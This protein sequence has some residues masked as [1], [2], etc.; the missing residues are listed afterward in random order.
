MNR[1]LKL[2]LDFLFGLIIPIIILSRFSDELGN[3]TAYVVS[4]LIPV[5]WV[6]I[7]LL[8]IT[9]RFNFITSFLGLNAVLRGILAFWF[10]DGVA[11][12][13]KDSASSLLWVV[14]FGGSL[15]YG[16]PLFGAFVEQGLGPQDTQQE[17][18]IKEFFREKSVHRAI[19]Y[20]TLGMVVVSAVATVAN[21]FLNLRIVTA[22]FGTSGFNLQ[23]AESNAIARFA[24]A[25]PEA[26]ALMVLMGFVLRTVYSALPQ[27]EGVEDF[28]ELMKVREERRSRN[29]ANT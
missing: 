5:A 7:D 15:V 10:V 17:R 21:F 23:V 26:L 19:W 12:A 8:F 3:I 16:R 6:I 14:I 27:V 13:F 25:I 24:I 20:G 29:S 1:T 4:A 28:W 22:E 2:G 18:S 9:K 11:Y